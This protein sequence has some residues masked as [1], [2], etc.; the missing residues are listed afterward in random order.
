M[1]NLIAIA[2][3]AGILSAQALSAQPKMENQKIME[4]SKYGLNGKLIAKEGSG[5]QLSTI[6]LQASELLTKRSECYLYLVSIDQSNP[7]WVWVTEVWESME[8]HDQSLS[9]PEVRNLIGQGIPLMS[10]N[11][12]K[13]VS[14]DVLGGY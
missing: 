4:Q 7:D 14:L 3:I 5:P 9:D 12:E 13:G 1:N 6:L 8:A 2:L 11:Q 10:E